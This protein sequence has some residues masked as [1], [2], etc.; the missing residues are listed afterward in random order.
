[1]Y[2]LHKVHRFR[3]MFRNMWVYVH[4][5]NG[6][7][8][9]RKKREENEI[10]AKQRKLKGEKGKVIETQK[11]NADGLTWVTTRICH[12]YLP[13]SVSSLPEIL[14]SIPCILIT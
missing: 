4:I 5:I 8:S 7:E 1:M 12:L 11:E 10:K 6:L 9:K 14:F 3:K 13:P 2:P